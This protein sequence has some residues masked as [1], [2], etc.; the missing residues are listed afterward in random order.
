MTKATL[1]RLGIDFEDFDVTHNTD[2]EEEM[3]IRSQRNTVPQIFINGKHLGGNDDLQAALKS[4]KL[5][6]ILETQKEVA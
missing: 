3:R 4:G 1:N 2:L 6:K 5:H